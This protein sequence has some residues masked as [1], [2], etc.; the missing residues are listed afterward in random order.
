MAPKGVLKVVLL[1]KQKQGK[2]LFQINERRLAE[3][4]HFFALKYGMKMNITIG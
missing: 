1:K 2:C 3:L 4:N